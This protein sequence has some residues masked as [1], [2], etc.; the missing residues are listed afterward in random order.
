MVQIPTFENKN[1]SQRT[2]GVP[3]AIPNVSDGATLPFRQLSNQADKLTGIASQFQKAEAD[4]EVALDKLNTQQQIKEYQLNEKYKTDVFKLTEELE[5]DFR[6]SELT[7]NRKTKV[8]S[9][10]NSILS[11]INEAKINV[12]ANQDTTTS[13]EDWDKATKKIYNN[14][15]KNIDDD[16]VK[17]LFTAKYNDLLAIENIDVGSN[18]RKIDVGNAITQFNIDKQNLFNDY[19]NYPEGHPKR[20]AALKKLFGGTIDDPNIFIEA[21]GD[22]IL[23]KLPDLAIIEAQK[24]LFSLEATKMVDENPKQFLKLLEQGYWQN[25]LEP[26][27][28]IKLEQPAIDN[29]R[30]MDIDTLVAFMPVDPDMT[31]EDAEELYVEAKT[32]NFGGN[33][34]LQEVYN[35][36]DAQGKSDFN[37]AINQQRSHVRTEISFQQT[38]ESKAEIDANNDLYVD[39]F[40]QITLGNLNIS[41]IDNIEFEGK[42]GTQYKTLLKDLIAKREQ[43][44]LPTDQNLK[45]HDKIFK[46]IMNGEIQ[47][48]TDQ[49]IMHDNE[50]KSILELTGGEDGLGTNQTQDFYNLIANRNN[51]DVILNAKYFEEFVSANK[52]NIL[53]NAALAEL[54]LKAE[55]RFFQ[56]KI[57][58]KQRF[59]QGIK[60]GKNVFE[61]LDKTSEHYILKDLQSYIPTKET[62]TNEVKESMTFKEEENVDNP[63]P[64]IGPNQTWDEFTKSDPY[65]KWQKLK[66]SQ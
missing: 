15:I 25:R 51:T 52:E 4:Q 45:L 5:S 38:Q 60:D 54:N 27:T 28:L 8:K 61:L 42:L 26:A 2:S 33:E 31:I 44:L 21:A 11:L 48:I 56:F 24:E 43:N 7:L 18:I 1:V 63:M 9:T 35:E 62:Q 12:L 3:F 65:L 47:S 40:E 50:N 17:Q 14:A 59:D 53:G 36:L 13:K 39:T 37:K 32:G 57:I 64:Q 46:K 58:M 22:L 23:D 19:L 41:D 20:T 29:A 66:D 49:V 6:K 10:Y 16:V 55:P 30:A 34:E